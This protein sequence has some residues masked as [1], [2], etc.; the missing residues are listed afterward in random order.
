MILHKAQAQ[1][2]ITRLRNY[3]SRNLNE[4]IIRAN[5]KDKVIT[6]WKKF[7]NYSLSQT[8]S[9]DQ[10]KTT[11]DFHLN[12]KTPKWLSKQLN[13]VSPSMSSTSAYQFDHIVFYE[14]NKNYIFTI[15]V[16]NPWEH[17]VT[18]SMQEEGL[19]LLGSYE[20]INQKFDIMKSYR[21]FTQA[22]KVMD[23]DDIKRLIRQVPKNESVKLLSDSKFSKISIEDAILI[24]INNLV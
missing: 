7:F 21:R 11:H 22:F 8:Y 6:I 4:T 16:F 3:S 17:V 23:A 1:E 13:L 12:F 10:N 15:E 2:T 24:N 20:M 14:Y 18:L 19:A 5:N 9:V